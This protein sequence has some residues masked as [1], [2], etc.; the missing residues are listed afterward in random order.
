MTNFVLK[1][2]ENPLLLEIY[3]KAASIIQILP[4]YITEEKFDERN[5][6]NVPLK[7]EDLQIEL[8]PRNEIES[9]AHHEESNV[10][11]T[12]WIQH[13]NNGCLCMA[14][15]YKGQIAAYSWCDPNYL[16]FK[17]RVVK[18]KQNE[19]ALFGARTYKAFRGN[20]LAPYV[21]YEFYKLLKQR[22]IERFYS[23]TLW[24]NTSSMKFKRKLGARNVELSLYVSL[25]RKYRLH[26]RLRN[27][28]GQSQVVS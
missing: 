15:R 17:G 13:V 20:N 12:E 27:L 8:L 14:V 23:T 5:E 11:A 24:S 6:I 16:R 3:R 18:L 2:Q 9:L 28:A 22:G 10:A 21:R 4:Y 26:F 25:F 1:I 19:A 7:K